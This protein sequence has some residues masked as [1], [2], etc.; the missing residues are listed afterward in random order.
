MNIRKISINDLNSY[1]DHLVRHLPERGIDGILTQPFSPNEPIDREDL[2]LKV[3]KRLTTPAGEGN[4]EV[5]WGLFDDQKMVGHL[6]LRGTAMPAFSHR[7]NLGMGIE[8]SHRGKGFG[9]KL[10][11][12][13]V[14]WAQ[15]QTFLSWIDLNVFAHN[16]VAIKLY[17]GFGFSEVGKTVDRLRVDGQSIDDYH[18][19]LKVSQVE[20]SATFCTFLS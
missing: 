5:S 9:K 3:S 4:W 18:F 19:V 16:D 12:Q 14:E 10:V 6:E 1:V 13:A 20:P 7:A 2:K 17:K 11:S 15:K 8:A